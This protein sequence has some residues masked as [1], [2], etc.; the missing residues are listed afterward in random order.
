MTSRHVTISTIHQ[1][2]SNQ[3]PSREKLFLLFLVEAKYVTGEKER[4]RE[5]ETEE[6]LRESR[7]HGE[8][9][10]RGGGGCRRAQTRPRLEKVHA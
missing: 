7:L 2:L 9:H 1:N 3:F 4:K 8:M 5:R 6:R 10:T